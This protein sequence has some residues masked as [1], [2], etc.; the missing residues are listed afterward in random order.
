MN[1]DRQL[2]RV[3]FSP[4][5]EYLVA[6]GFDPAV[7]RWRV[8]DTAF[9]P[10]PALEGHNG[11]VQALAFHPDRR[12][13]VTGD[14][15]GELRVWN[16]ADREARPVRVTAA[17]HD[18]WLRDIA[19]SADG[20]LIASCGMDQKVRLWSAEDGRRLH[21]LNGHGAD[22]FA[23]AFHPDGRSLVSGD[24]FGNVH[25][26]DVTSG[27]RTRTFDARPLYMQSRLQDVGGVRVLRFDASGRMLACAGTRPSVGGNVQG[28]PTILLFDTETGRVQHTLA[29]GGGGDGFVYDL[30]FHTD[31]FLMAVAS[32]NPGTGKFFFQYPTDRE[33]FYLGTTMPNCQSLAVHPDGRRVV[34]AATNGNSNGNGR[35]LRNGEY[36][37]N[38]SP[39]HLWEIP[40]AS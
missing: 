27:Q 33:P 4:C 9:E 30:A 13:L 17:A 39:L 18:G 7:R 36:P 1:A 20:R 23:V 5:G 32:G 6:G 3:R 34:V 25:Q 31:G 8:T 14:S 26:W 2:S 29:V 24:Q 22:V 10:L 35:P 15:W 37:G 16:Y 28:V 40:A 11:W 38:F 19:I 21:D 12:R